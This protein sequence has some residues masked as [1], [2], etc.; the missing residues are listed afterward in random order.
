MKTVTP[1]ATAKLISKVVHML[2]FYSSEERLKC[3]LLP[4]FKSE[5]ARNNDM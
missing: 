5:L 2:T 3:E 4:N 1:K